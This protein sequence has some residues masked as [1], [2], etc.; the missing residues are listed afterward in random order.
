MTASLSL[1]D[2][3]KISEPTRQRVRN[4]AAK[5]GYRPDPEISRLM[6]RLRLSRRIR[7]AEVIATLDLQWNAATAI[8]GYQASVGRGIARRA[9]ALGFG[10][11]R[12][13]L[14][15]YDGD[16][17]KMLRVVR[18]RGI[19]GA[20]LLPPDQLP[21]ALPTDVRWD[22][23]SIVAATTSILSPRFHQVV[24]NQ[25]YNM[26]TLVEKVQR[27]GYVRLGA[28]FSA[29]LEERTAHQYTLALT[30]HG[31]RDR[32]LVLPQTARAPATI[33]HVTEWLQARNPDVVLTAEVELVSE[34]LRQTG[35]AES[36]RVV[37]LKPGNPA[38]PFQDQ[39]PELI[40]ES[41]VSLVTGMMYSNERGVPEHPRV[42][43][44]DGVFRLEDLPTP[45]PRN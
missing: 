15:D 27:K 24:P 13:R 1:R 34:C 14:L 8:D 17:R 40:G 5:L 33:A 37:A 42:T 2:S 3:P 9:E 31:H 44:I 11:S 18:S 6:G 25:L 19:D 32:I 16:L 28:I 22:E 7:G 41:A 45:A 35:E 43:T 12:F 20:I 10:V 26:M 21:M 30:W 39:L 23:L 36:I 38:I 29:T 4:A